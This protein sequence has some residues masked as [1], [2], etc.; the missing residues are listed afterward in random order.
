M[1]APQPRSEQPKPLDARGLQPEISSFRLHLAAEGKAATTVRTYTEA[2]RWFAA[3]HLIA[4]A[5]RTGWEEV[6]KQDVQQWIACL[7]D[8]YSSAYASNQF[9]AL[10]QFFKWL[11]AEDE[12]PDPM[13]GVKPPHVPDKPVPV[14]T[15]AELKR[16]E[17]ACA[18]RGFQERRDAAV[19]AVFEATGIRLSELAGIRYDPGDPRRSDVDLWYREITVHGKSRKTGRSRSATTPPAPSTATSAPAPGMPRPTGRSYGS[20]STT[21]AR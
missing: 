10:Q 20:A 2:V 12:I 21:A 3:A 16:L 5:G 6:G 13:A 15:G 14:F 18:G 9:R 4:Q 1:T 19:I 11:H 7:L 17:R 8:H